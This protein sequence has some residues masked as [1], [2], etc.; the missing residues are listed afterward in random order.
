[1]LKIIAVQI[2]GLSNVGHDT[3]LAAVFGPKT[4]LKKKKKKNVY[5]AFSIRFVFS[6]KITLLPL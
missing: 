4:R 1:M 2:T 3:G 6:D 5:G